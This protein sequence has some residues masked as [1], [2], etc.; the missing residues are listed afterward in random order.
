MAQISAYKV[1]ASPHKTGKDTTRRLMLDV[2]I[3]L[4]PC[5][6]AGVVFYGLWALLL[7]VICMATCFASEQLCN[8]I[9]RKPFTF[10]FSALVTGLILGLNLPPRAPWYIPVIG[11]VFAIVLVKM[12]FGG[13]GKN[14]ANPAA[15]ARVFLLLA[16]SGVMTSWIGADISGN[17]LA[18][19][20]TTSA[21]YLGG[22]A[23]AF[24]DSFLGVR[25]YWGQVLQLLFGYTGG[26]IGETCVPAIAA[27]FVYLTVRRVI[28]WRIPLSYL[29]TAAV[30][31]LICYG[32]AGEILL[33]LLSGGLLFGAVFMATDY[34]TSPKWR[35][36]RILYGIGL[37]IVTMLIRAFGTYPEGVS[38]A[39][40][41]MNLLVPLMDKYILPVRFG[42]LTKRGKPRPEIMK[43]TMRALC[44]AMALSLVVAVPVLATREEPF[45]PVYVQS[46][47]QD[48]SGSY[49]FEVTGG[50]YL[51]EYDYTQELAYTVTI[52]PE[53]G[54]VSTIVPVRQS[55][56]GYE[57][58]LEFFVGK[59]EAEIAG[60]TDLTDPEEAP[61]DGTSS[62]TVTNT[63]LR[64]MVLECF[65]VMERAEAGNG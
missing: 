50:A 25:G 58:Y 32:D 48:E 43:W 51:A 38:L 11:G 18:V 17:F 40:L 28:D 42:E 44:L 36:N 7:V 65:E 8:L 30:M 45:E 52:A 64:A 14:F 35:Y 54:R 56:M 33:Q 22:G 2:L 49:V 46:Y 1:S 59:T 41:I 37:G 63:A 31:A 39:I 53:T 62:A 55:T 47:T 20:G 4:A 16:Y 23:A 34:A 26:S 21:T 5:L 12:L 3:A 60:L 27:G 15:T 29:L 19:D 61:T 13:L 57:A 9:R 24:A 6:A 10:D